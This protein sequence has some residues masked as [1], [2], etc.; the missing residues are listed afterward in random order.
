MLYRET[1]YLTLLYTM[2]KNKINIS[3]ESLLQQL[4][5]I[6]KSPK[7]FLE[8]IEGLEDAEIDCKILNTDD[9]MIIWYIDPNVVSRKLESAAILLAL[10]NI[11][12][13]IQFFA[14]NEKKMSELYSSMFLA[15]KE[16]S[17]K[18]NFAIFPVITNQFSEALKAKHRL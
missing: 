18:N 7:E 9:L 10:Y 16:Y 11:F 17:V 8:K 6:R 15:L 4:N 13:A 3:E 12:Y 1:R 5:E 2:D 14:N